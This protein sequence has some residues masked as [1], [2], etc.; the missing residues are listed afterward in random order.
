LQLIELGL[1]MQ[2][3]PVF[4]TVG[5]AYGFAFGRY[6]STLSIIWLPLLIL[7]VLAYFL[8]LPRFPEMLRIF[9]QIAQH[10]EDNAAN[11]QLLTQFN[12]SAA[13]LQLFNLIELAFGV[14]ILSGITKEALGLRTGSRLYYL[15][16]GSSELYVLVAVILM[17][18]IIFGVVMAAFLGGLVVGL[19]G[20]LAAGAAGSGNGPTAAQAIIAL[21][22]GLG[23]FVGAFYVLAR[24]LFLLVPASIA[25]NVVGIGRS[26]QLAHGNVLR[27]FATLLLTLLPLALIE[28]VVVSALAVPMVMQF[29][30]EQKRGGQQAVE[31]HVQALLHAAPEYLIGLAIVGFLIAPVVY[32]LLVSLPAFAYRALVPA[33]APG[34]AAHS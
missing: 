22:V 7:L 34:A 5:H 26:W 16:F 12:R 4:Q 30:D 19:I 23:V 3:I 29:V 15:Q 2:K 25:E 18:V 20:V 11:T 31:Q 13:Y 10:P 24:S 28:I 27:I 17:V 33:G 32:G 6:L 21:I 1:S 14:I 9:S 8:V